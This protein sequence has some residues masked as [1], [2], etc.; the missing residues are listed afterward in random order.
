MIRVDES[1]GG[2][3]SLIEGGGRFSRG[4][5]QRKKAR[6]LKDELGRRK[7]PLSCIT[8]PRGEGKV[9]LPLKRKI[10]VQKG[11]TAISRDEKRARLQKEAWT[12]GKK[13]S[14]RA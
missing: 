13:T 9:L 10:H 12:E 6:R 3:A 8:W 5:L 7:W 4:S 11:F 14:S 2:G 1:A